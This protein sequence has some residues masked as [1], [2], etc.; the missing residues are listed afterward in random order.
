MDARREARCSLAAMQ[1]DVAG[2]VRVA[3]LAWRSATGG[4]V[5]TVVA[6]TTYRLAPVVCELLH[7][8]D[9]VTIRDVFWDEDPRASL[10]APSDLVPLKSRPEVMLVGHAVAPNGGKV[11]S[12]RTRM[13]VGSVDKEIEVWADRA[14]TLDGTLRLGVPFSRMPLRWERAGG[15]PETSN[16]VGILQGIADNYGQ[17]AVPNLQPIDCA[18]HAPETFVPP[19][20]F[21][22]IAPAWWS[23]SSKLGARGDA[24]IRRGIHDTDLPTDLDPA[25]FQAAPPDQLLDVLRPDERIVLENLLPDHARLVTSLP[26]VAPTIHI[27]VPGAPPYE[28]RISPDTLFID[29]DRRVCTL[30]FR[31]LLPM[32]SAPRAAR[33]SVR[34]DAPDDGDRRVYS[35]PAPDAEVTLLTVDDEDGPQ[36][37]PV[38]EAKRS[39]VTLPFQ[40]VPADG[41]PPRARQDDAGGRVSSPPS[42]LPFATSRSQLSAPP[43]IPAAPPAPAPPAPLQAASPHQVLSGAASTPPSASPWARGGEVIAQA[44]DAPLQ[45]PTAVAV[46]KSS[47]PS[48]PASP[49]LS[50][51]ARA[52]AP[53]WSKKPRPDPVSERDRAQ[54]GGSIGVAPRGAVAASNAAADAAASAAASAAA[55][56]E[57]RIDEAKS[58]SVRGAPGLDLLGYD[59]AALARVRASRTFR[60][61]L[62]EGGGR[63]SPTTVDPRSRFPARDWS[64]LMRVLTQG[65]PTDLARLRAALDEAL[66][67][68][69]GFTPPLTVL[70]GDL[71]I[72]FERRDWLET[73]IVALTPFAG[74]DK[75]IKDA[76]A[77][78]NEILRRPAWM[79]PDAFD[80]GITLLR[81]ALGEGGRAS[82]FDARVERALLIDRRFARRSVF[83]GPRVRSELS[84]AVERGAVAAPLASS[85]RPPQPPPFAL[86][87]YLP[88]SLAER[89]PLIPR[90]S[91]RILVELRLREDAD[92][93]SLEVADVIALARDLRRPERIG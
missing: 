35:D 88:D 87:C 85:A 47:L 28:L 6:K 9:D 40:A 31:A 41:P 26:G 38:V 45:Q 83:G 68:R 80:A 81:D 71:H 49:A 61:L 66:D 19:I 3:S 20:A 12:L 90:L 32:P 11:A 84:F 23:R 15:G 8:P 42:A 79:A 67:D 65:E 29:T 4:P 43:L 50:S 86:P 82:A 74:G 34:L 7:E 76:L 60:M 46:S 55:A 52:Q 69:T 92:D 73:A 70:A 56:P 48:A 17:A 62:G 72:G 30:A 5:L 1:I 54:D 22:P 64:E 18:V 21:A 89:W 2:P 58:K 14:W 16:P 78:A 53:A 24:W 44:P 36:P 37:A 27:E 59:E 39:R 93:T 51:D 13:I 75:K 57:A 63:W 10:Y 91:V 33:L 25:F 77:L